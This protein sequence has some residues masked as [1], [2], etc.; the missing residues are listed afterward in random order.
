MVAAYPQLRSEICF[1]DEN[2]QNF[3]LEIGEPGFELSLRER[4]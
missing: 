1:M 2:L 4:I 3:L